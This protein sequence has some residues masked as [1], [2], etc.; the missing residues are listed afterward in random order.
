LSPS[1]VGGIKAEGSK[2]DEIGEGCV[3]VGLDKRLDV[4][5]LVEDNKRGGSISVGDDGLDGA[6][7]SCEGNVRGEE[8]KS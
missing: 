7:T 6:E 5:R 1:R 3:D 2:G 4:I 8:M